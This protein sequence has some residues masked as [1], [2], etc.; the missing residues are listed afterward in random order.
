MAT[1]FHRR[2]PAESGKDVGGTPTGESLENRSGRRDLRGGE[3]Q[4]GSKIRDRLRQ[5]TEL[6]ELSREA[7]IVVDGTDRVVYWNHGAE[8]LYGWPHDHA[9]GQNPL[10]LL[11]TELPRSLPQI[12]N[13]LRQEPYWDCE[14]QQTTREGNH[15]AVASRWALWRDSDGKILGRFQLDTDITKRKQVEQELRVLSGRLLNLQDEE[16]RRFARDLHD[17]VGQLLAGA[18]MNLSLVQKKLSDIDAPNMKLLSEGNHLLEEALR[19]IRTLSYLLHPPLLD[20]VGLISA[21]RWYVSGF[22]ERSQI[23][24]Q[25]EVPEGL[26]RFRR[27]LELALFRI[28]QESLTN[29]HRHSG[30]SV[31]KITITKAPAQLRLK[32]EDRGKG[33]KLPIGTPATSTHGVGISGIRERVR[34]L[35][36]QMQVRS[37]NWG[38]AIEVLFPL[39]EAVSSK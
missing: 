14:L 36:G 19:E 27:E 18:S 15:I 35:G 20:E 26:G 38:T 10:Q 37:G 23:Q 30:S 3:P 11:R 13:I 12:E 21:L 24:V 6:L 8:K 34:Q 22:A 4:L 31:A 28:V 25:L 7:V 1:D 32:V 17:S 16:R 2:I 33:M 39:E 29:V 5:T 9:L